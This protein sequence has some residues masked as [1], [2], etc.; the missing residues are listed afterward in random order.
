MTVMEIAEKNGAQAYTSASHGIQSK[1]AYEKNDYNI[2]THHDGLGLSITLQKDQKSSST[3]INSF[4]ANDIEE[5]IKLSL[6]MA[7]YSI[8]DPYLGLAQKSDYVQ[9]PMFFD[10]QVIDMGMKELKDLTTHLIQSSSDDPRILLESVNMEKS[11]STRVLANSNGMIASDYNAS[12]NWFIMGIAKDGDDLTSMDYHGDFSYQT[13][14]LDSKLTQ[15][16]SHFKKKM[17]SF[18]GSKKGESY[19]GLI[20]LPPS[21]TEEFIIDSIVFHLKGSNIMDGKSRWEHHLGKKIGNSNL[22]LEDQPHNPELRGCTGF[23]GE[24]VPTQN[25]HL[26]QDGVIKNQ[27][28]TIY[29]SNRR[30]TKPTGN[31]SGPHAAVMPEGNISW[32]EMIKDIP[33]LILPSRFSGNFDPLSGDFSGI[34]KGSQY[35]RHGE[36]LGCL[37][38]TMIAGNI[39]ETLERDLKFSKERESDFGYYKLPYALIDGISVTSN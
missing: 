8:A 18:L 22:T 23:S 39:F 24:G 15:T 33:Q 9:L 2:A 10:Q 14:D 35:Y 36:H 13:D 26:V 29:T 34:A 20:L 5:A 25:M 30:K 17:L 7:K 1:I 28:D 31:G 21:L 3:S 6:E 19:K 16:S 11:I 27:L 38:E 12:L 37:K 32:K 4:S